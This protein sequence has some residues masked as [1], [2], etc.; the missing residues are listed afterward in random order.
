MDIHES[1]LVRIAFKA[2][3]ASLLSVWTTSTTTSPSWG[4]R[5]QMGKEY[6][7]HWEFR[8]HYGWATNCHSAGRRE[9]LKNF[10]SMKA[11]L[12][13]F[14]DSL[15]KDWY[16]VEEL[17]WLGQLGQKKGKQHRI[18]IVNIYQTNQRD[19][20]VTDGAGKLCQSTMLAQNFDQQDTCDQPDSRTCSIAL[21][22]AL[23]QKAH[24]RDAIVWWWGITKGH[25]ETNVHA[26]NAQKDSS[27]DRW[28]N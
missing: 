15:A 1:D 16:Y 5:Q 21:A 20:L 23:E 27:Q 3:K 25:T 13:E 8:D 28:S 2:G 14:G 22:N 24:R 18:A 4:P 17:P 11:S 9:G 26:W 6:P 19:A 10:S 12:V 7:C